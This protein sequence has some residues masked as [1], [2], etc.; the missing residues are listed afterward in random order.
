MSVVTRTY[1]SEWALG[2]VSCG[3]KSVLHGFLLPQHGL[4]LLTLQVTDGQFKRELGILAITFN[5][6]SASPLLETQVVGLQYTLSKNTLRRCSMTSLWP[7][8][9]TR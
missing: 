5:S 2:T 1:L 3:L 8:L 7:M 6:L 4:V 9:A